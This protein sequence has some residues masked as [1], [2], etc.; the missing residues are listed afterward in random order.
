MGFYQQIKERLDM[1]IGTVWGEPLVWKNA[2]ELF[3]SFSNVNS[4]IPRSALAMAGFALH[5]LEHSAGFDRLPG[6]VLSVLHVMLTVL[7]QLGCS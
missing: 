6:R 7:Q 5:W 2:S 4:V 3:R 1:K